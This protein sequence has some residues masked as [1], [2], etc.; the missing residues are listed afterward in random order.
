M[1]SSNR[2]I[3]LADDDSLLSRRI[4]LFAWAL[5]ACW[6]LFIG[7]SWFWTLQSEQKVLHKIALAE[8]RAVIERDALYRSWGSSHGGVYVPVTPQTPPNPYLSHVPERDIR[9]PSGK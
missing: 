8:A 4:R 6:T 5:A 7:V 1:H 9:T 3:N 2:K